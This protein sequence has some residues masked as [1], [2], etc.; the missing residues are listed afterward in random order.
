MPELCNELQAGLEENLYYRH[1]V[2]VRQLAPVEVGILD[3]QG[4]SAWLVY[5]SSTARTRT[6]KR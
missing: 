2:A 4:E 5:E 3:P 6:E 1:A